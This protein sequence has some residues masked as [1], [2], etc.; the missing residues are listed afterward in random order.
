MPETWTF[1]VRYGKHQML[2][3]QLVVIQ[4]GQYIINNSRPLTGQ[5]KS[6]LAVGFRLSLILFI[7][8]RGF[9]Q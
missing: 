1:S 3:I 8:S 6:Q 2:H 9:T 5:S 4:V 7:I